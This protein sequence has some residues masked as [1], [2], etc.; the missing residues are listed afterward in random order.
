[1]KYQENEN[2]SGGHLSL[3]SHISF[4]SS[5]T[6]PSVDS[7]YEKGE[8][9]QL[10]TATIAVGPSITTLDKITA[11]DKLKRSSSNTT[12]TVTRTSSSNKT[13]INLRECHFW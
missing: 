8:S 13:S 2:A 12:S 5:E 3:E 9:T 11:N 1:M 7:D 10:Q 4:S 6:D